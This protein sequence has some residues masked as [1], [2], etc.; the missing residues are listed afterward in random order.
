MDGIAPEDDGA[1]RLGE[2]PSNDVHQRGLP[3]TIFAYDGVDLA[4]FHLQFHVVQGPG[5]GKVLHDA[6]EF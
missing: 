1:L 2:Y 4:A 6:F 5:A 3:R